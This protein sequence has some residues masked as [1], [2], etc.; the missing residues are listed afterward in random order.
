MLA[1]NALLHYASYGDGFLSEPHEHE[2]MPLLVYAA[3]CLV[4]LDN[5]AA[6]I[7]VTLRMCVCVLSEVDH[8]NRWPFSCK[9]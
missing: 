6:I 3:R 8:V 9:C 1:N 5:Q 4:K 7:R 2:A